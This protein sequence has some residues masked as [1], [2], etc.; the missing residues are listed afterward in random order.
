MIEP[1]L[2]GICGVIVWSSVWINTLV[3]IAISERYYKGALTDYMAPTN[4]IEDSGLI[5]EYVLFALAVM[6]SVIASFLS[7]A[8]LLLA[9]METLQVK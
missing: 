3:V 8:F 7:L 6:T 9:I 5:L 2:C 4:G 1:N